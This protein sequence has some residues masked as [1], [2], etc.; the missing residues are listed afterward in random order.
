MHAPGGPRRRKR[1]IIRFFE[2]FA[3]EN[4]EIRAPQAGWNRARPAP[5]REPA[6]ADQVMHAE[7]RAPPAEQVGPKEE[8]IGL[9]VMPDE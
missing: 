6:K 2:Q 7:A 9:V 1:L 3:A 4:T 5:R 8:T